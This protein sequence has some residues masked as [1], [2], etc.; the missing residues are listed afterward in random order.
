MQAGAVGVE[1]NLPKERSRAKSAGGKESSQICRRKGVEPNLPE[2]I[3]IQCTARLQILCYLKWK[4]L[5]LKIMTWSQST[6]FAMIPLDIET[7]FLIDWPSFFSLTRTQRVRMISNVH[8]CQ[9]KR[10]ENNGTANSF[11]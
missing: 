3:I 10:D 5:I 9:D 7:H 2:E 4:C 1:P 6:T 8:N 11:V